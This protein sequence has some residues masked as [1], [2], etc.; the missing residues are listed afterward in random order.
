[1]LISIF[2]TDGDISRI[3][4]DYELPYQF[5]ACGCCSKLPVYRKITSIII[6][7]KKA[8]RLNSNCSM[9]KC[10]LNLIFHWIIF[11]F[12]GYINSFFKMEFQEKSVEISKE[13]IGNAINI[14]LNMIPLISINKTLKTLLTSKMKEVFKCFLKKI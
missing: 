14:L 9:F 12:K 7:N 8:L 6:D 4:I 1:M 13:I 3:K 2:V 5:K 11:L 10:R